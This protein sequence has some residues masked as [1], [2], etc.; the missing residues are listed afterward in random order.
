M[1]MKTPFILP[2]YRKLGQQLNSLPGYP[3]QLECHHPGTQHQTCRNR[4]QARYSN[5][6]S[7]RLLTTDCKRTVP[8]SFTNYCHR[9]LGIMR[10]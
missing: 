7:Q 8:F 6:T 3:L 1:R 10:Y 5:K 2:S 9:N 4:T